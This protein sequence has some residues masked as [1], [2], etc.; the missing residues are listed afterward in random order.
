[1]KR[2]SG[3]RS[4]S[5]YRHDNYFGEHGTIDS[6]PEKRLSPVKHLNMDNRQVCTAGLTGVWAEENTRESIWA[7]VWRKETYAT[8]GLRMKVRLFGGWEYD[9][10]VLK[11]KDWVK[12]GYAKGVPMGG[13]LL[14]AKSKAPSFIVWAE[15]D[16]TSA[17]LDRIQII[18]GWARNGQSFR[19]DL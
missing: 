9:P 18:K 7:A 1:M 14:A 10:A 8:S 17:N 13:D 11:Q 3:R 19:E 4:A 5:A 15:S 16:P 2:K 12:I 6:T